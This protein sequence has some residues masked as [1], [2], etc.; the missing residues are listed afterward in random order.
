MNAM[1]R[2]IFKYL[3]W[4]SLN[5]ALIVSVILLIAVVN[6]VNKLPPIAELLDDRKRGSVTLLDQHNNVFAWRGNQ[7]GGILKSNSLNRVLHDAIISVEIEH[8]I[9]TLG[10]Q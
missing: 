5:V 2:K 6:Y 3:F 7:F 10:F 9:R 4:L 8:F 1:L